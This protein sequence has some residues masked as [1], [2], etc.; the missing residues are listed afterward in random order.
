VSLGVRGK[1]VEYHCFRGAGC[2]TNHHLLVVKVRERERERER[3]SVS[4]QAV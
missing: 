3:L 2:D 4:K 1:K